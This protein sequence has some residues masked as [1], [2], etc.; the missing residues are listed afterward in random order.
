MKITYFPN[1]IALNGAPVLTAFLQGCQKLGV[2]VSPNNMTADAAVIWSVVW[3]GRTKLNRQV[4]Q[5]FLSTGR[6]VILLE[7]GMIQRGQSWRMALMQ[8][9]G[10]VSY[11]ES[12]DSAR[13]ALLGLDL[14][15]W[16][17]SG[18][19]IVIATQRTDSEQWK[20]QPDISTWLAMTI[21]TIK[22]HSDRPIVVRPHPRQRVSVP[23]GCQI[24]IPARVAGTYDS[25]NFE[26]MLNN[27]WAVVNW[28]SSPGIQAILNGVPAF[29][30]KSSLAT[31]V[32]NLD[33]ADIEN[34][35]R[36][37]RSEWLV[38]LS[39]TEWLLEEISAGIP[40]KRLNGLFG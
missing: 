30:D 24:D 19:K 13:P 6:P 1:Q 37:N 21:R 35:K 28:N 17:M 25:F 29:V 11:A 9:D 38:D 18:K 5:E 10:S 22:A 34:P 20:N 4:Y 27:V 16:S 8:S 15:P 2:A 7:V 31:P 32:G 26:D 23:S 40:F 3:A 39:H 12:T 33:L 14:K 36:P